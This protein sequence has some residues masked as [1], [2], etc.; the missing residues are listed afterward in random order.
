MFARTTSRAPRWSLGYV[1]LAAKDMFLAAEDVFLAVPRA[2]G[3]R[4]RES[5]G[6]AAAGREHAFAPGQPVRR[7]PRPYV[8]SSPRG[9]STACDKVAR[10]RAG[11]VVG[12]RSA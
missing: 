8:V 5:E 9:C 7:G 12:R 3:L 10:H 4:S 1:R 6:R 11:R 2:S